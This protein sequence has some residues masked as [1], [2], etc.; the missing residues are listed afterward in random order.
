[1]DNIIIDGMKKESK[2]ARNLM[3]FGFVL[4]LLTFLYMYVNN[5]S[6]KDK[7]VLV[8]FILYLSFG[9]FG[10]YVWLYDI[11]YS[12]KITKEK[13]LL[14]TLFRKVEINICSIEKYTCKRYRKSVFYQ[15]NLFIKDKRILVN[16]RYKD[17]F[18]K[19]LEENSVEQISK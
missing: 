11:K 5:K 9:I 13:I 12:L 18:I 16:T 19:I 6:L 7:E 10:F 1:M 15:F 2:L 14:K 17:E 4:F 8:M 3:F